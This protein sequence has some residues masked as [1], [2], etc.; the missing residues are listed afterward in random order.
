VRFIFAD[1][2]H[3]HT[4]H[5][6]KLR[7]KIEKFPYPGIIWNKVQDIVLELPE[8]MAAYRSL[9]G[10]RTKANLSNY[11]NKLRREFNF[12]FDLAAGKEIDPAAI[13]EIIGLHR[14]RMRNKK[15]VSAIDAALEDKIIRFS[16]SYG[17]VG[18]VR[19]N[20]RVAAGTICYGV[21]GHCYADVIAH[22]PA[23]NKYSIGQVCIYLMIQSLIERGMHAFHLAEGRN[24]YKYRLLG[25]NRDLYFL[26]IFRSELVKGI[27]VFRHIDRFRYA[28]TL[29]NMLKYKYLGRTKEVFSEKRGKLWQWLGW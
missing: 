13:R 28:T 17:I 26:S 15:M 18:T 20:G 27:G 1:Y 11:S 3:V 10:K 19:L 9:L 7:G 14:L 16:R 2:P 8:T 25:E 24:D 22:D 21:G 6:N 4:I 12:A 23:Y 5:F 29:K